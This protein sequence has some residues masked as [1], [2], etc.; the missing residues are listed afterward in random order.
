MHTITLELRV[1]AYGTLKRGFPNHEP[2]C[3]RVLQIH[4]AW[5]RGR[6]FKL[7]AE[8]PVMTVPHDDILAYGTADAL[9]DIDAQEKFQAALRTGKIP[10]FVSSAGGAGWRK[11]RGEL[12]IFDDP[13]T[14]L[15]LLDCL[16]EFRPG[17]SSTYIRALVFVTLA[18]G[19][20]TS[21]WTYI[22]G[23]DPAGLEEYAEESWELCRPVVPRKTY[24]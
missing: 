10:G 22:A 9:S 5:L 14:R 23:F 16:E 24:G 7:G 15:L 12:L 17:R 18:D 8:A 3:A 1:F 2:Y 20:K 6:L 19:L 4:P 11:V 13:Q 21:A